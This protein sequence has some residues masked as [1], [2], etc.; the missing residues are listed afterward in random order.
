[1]SSRLTKDALKEALRESGLWEEGGAGREA[2]KETLREELDVHSSLDRL[3][4]LRDGIDSHY[5][6]H[7]I[8]VDGIRQHIN[9]SEV[10]SF[11]PNTLTG[12]IEPPSGYYLAGVYSKRSFRFPVLTARTKIPSSGWE[13]YIGL[14]NAPGNLDGITAFRFLPNKDY[15]V[16]ILSLAG[17]YFTENRVGIANLLPSDFETAEH[18]YTIEVCKNM[19][20]FYV[21][22]SPIAF[23][24]I[25]AAEKAHDVSGP[26]YALLVSSAP[27]TKTLRAFVEVNETSSLIPTRLELSPTSLFVSEGVEISPK[28]LPLYL[29]Q[30]STK[31]AGY[32]IESGNVTSHP[33]PIFGYSGKT[34]LFQADQN[35]TLSIEV[36]TQTGNWRTYD[37]V[38]VSADTL[39]S[40]I[41][42]GDAVLARVTF[43]PSA[44]PA[45]INEAEVILR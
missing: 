31:M 25:N 30:S 41:M 40:Y 37:S 5:D 1:M 18:T 19:V 42:S 34:F 43:T 28:A 23:C 36:F 38:S 13:V 12:Y 39:L 20:S 35:G 14:E 22:R 32:S 8:N 9:A 7:V 3:R 21:D 33:V 27:M 45:T 11:D 44:Y 26:P 17:N 16:V 29:Y 10:W 24:L 2:L 15:Y 6:G 4:I